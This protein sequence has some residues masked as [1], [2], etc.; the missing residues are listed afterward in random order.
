MAIPEEDSSSL[1]KIPKLEDPAHSS[2]LGLVVKDH[3]VHLNSLHSFPSSQY[4]FGFLQPRRAD[5]DMNQHV[6]NVS[7][8]GWVLEVGSSHLLYIF[9]NSC[10]TDADAPFIFIFL[11]YFLIKSN[12]HIMEQLSKAPQHP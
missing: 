10:Y 4:A 8:I 7:Y 9:G 1:R 5:L 12:P 2:K 11:I 3:L 6:N